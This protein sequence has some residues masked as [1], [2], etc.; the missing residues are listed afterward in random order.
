M[1][2]RPRES[3]TQRKSMSLDSRLRGNERWGGQETCGYA[4]VDNRRACHALL[5]VNARRSTAYPPFAAHNARPKFDS[6]LTPRIVATS[7]SPRV[8]VARHRMGRAGSASC[9]LPC[10]QPSGGSRNVGANNRR[11]GAPRGERPTSLDA[12]RV[13]APA[14]VRHSPAKGAAA[15]ERLS[16][17]RSLRFVRGSKAKGENAKLGG[18]IASRERRCIGIFVSR[19]QRRTK[20]CAADPGPR[21]PVETTGTPDLRCT[22]SRCTASGART[23]KNGS[24]SIIRPSAA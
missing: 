14:G 12:R 20:S 6:A 1:S 9:A 4:F 2:A 18:V 16:A 24:D 5:T 8:L 19:A 22:V 7:R 3:G 10:K 21:F 17:P 15:P 13:A 11:S 23:P